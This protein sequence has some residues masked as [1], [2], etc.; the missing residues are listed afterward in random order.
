VKLAVVIPALDEH[1]RIVPSVQS[2]QLPGVEVLVVDGGSRD[3]TAELARGLGVRVLDV[4][5]GR[6]RQLAAGARTAA[7]NVLLFLHADSLL[8]GG[9]AE[10]VR[11][12]LADPGVAGGFFDLRFDERTFALR[13]VEWGA[14][15]RV[16][17]FSLPYGDQA[18]FVR[19]EVLEEIGGVPMVPLMEDLD[20]VQAI[21]TKGKLARVPLPVVTSA[22][23]YR[24]GGVLSTMLRHWLALIAW[25]LGIDRRRV[26]RWYAR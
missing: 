17:L 9:W 20:L 22:R 25:R 3:G 10:A 4:P 26:A 18:I 24:A 23:R 6:A 14:R 16:A 15:L 1:D 8:P 21:K 11:A 13:F 7:G 5:K 2:A 12:A 19:R